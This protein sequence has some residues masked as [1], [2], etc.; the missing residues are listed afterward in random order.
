MLEARIKQDMTE[1]MKA[2]DKDKVSCLRVLLAAVKN[3][4]KNLR[5]ELDDQEVLAVIRAEIKQVTESYEQFKAGHRDELAAKELAGLT[6]LKLYLPAEMSE[7]ELVSII[8]AAIAELGATKKDL[9]KVMKQ[10][11]TKVA[12]RA[13]GKRINAL[14]GSKLN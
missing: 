2:G 12:G 10:V 4:E 13:D 6:V 3:R 5:K 14:V 11:M 1:A 8:E 9:G 7:D